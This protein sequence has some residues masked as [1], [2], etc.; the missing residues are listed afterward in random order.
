MRYTLI[1]FVILFYACSIKKQ[2]AT[3]IYNNRDRIISLFASK[4]VFRSRG[5]NI[6]LLYTHNG[7]KTNKYFFEIIDNQFQFL[8]D[9]I[10][11]VPDLLHLKSERG[12][13]KYE[14]ELSSR[15]KP[16]INKMDELKIRD[17]RS[18]FAN[19]GI[20][21]NIYTRIKRSRIICA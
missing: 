14:R 13:E 15:L 1:G 3:V 12:D 11:Y 17:I 21:L 6:I 19:I 16:L 8:N 9:S 10:E 7:N 18:D 4:N 5:Q 2:E 20:G